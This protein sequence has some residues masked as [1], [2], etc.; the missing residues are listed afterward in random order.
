MVSIS[1]YLTVDRS[2]YYCIQFSFSEYGK[3]FRKPHKTYCR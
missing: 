1:I 3:C 2:T